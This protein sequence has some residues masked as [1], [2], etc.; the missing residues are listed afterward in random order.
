MR[1]FKKMLA[2]MVGAV[3]ILGNSV[4]GY[5]AG[6]PL[7][8]FKVVGYCSE[9]FNDPVE[10][11]QFD[12][13]TDVIYAFLIPGDDGTLIG[14]EKPEKLKALVAAA[15]SKGVRVSIAVG[16]WSYKN[17]PLQGNFEKMAGNVT[18]RKLFVKNTVQFLKAYQLDGLDLDWEFPTASAPYEALVRDLSV[19]LDAEGL[20]LSA[21]L[22][23]AWS[24]TGAPQ[25]SSLVTNTCLGYFDTINIMAYDADPT[26]PGHSPLW[27]ADTS[28][29]YWRLRGVPQEKII[30][31]VPFYGA[32]GWVQY[33]DIIKDN[34]DNAWRDRADI[35]VGTWGK[36]PVYY[37]GIATIQEKT[38]LALM[39][40][41][42][43]MIFDINEDT[44]DSS[45][46]LTA[47]HAVVEK[48]GGN[49]AGILDN[50]DLAVYGR[51][52]VFSE[53]SGEGVPYTD[54]QNRVMVPLRKCLEAIGASVA[55]DAQTQVITAARNGTTLTCTIGKREL[56]VNGTVIPMDT[57]AVIQESRTYVPVRFIY[58]AFGNTVT[59]HEN[60]RTVRVE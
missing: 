48:H 4:P 19:A 57:E 30:I 45:S 13:L 25:V 21:A 59:W 15:H 14:I 3:L 60:S 22:N 23:G 11:I 55:Y 38:R 34:P 31:G 46:L 42:G 12:K 54:Q 33:R 16:G 18:T 29:R 9:V 7:K 50:P 43:L 24:E 10:A 41:G 40:A 2:L 17:V 44:L 5:A 26:G 53:V 27:F 39:K 58:E 51:P 20:T 28:I 37:N 32:P 6:D 47:I 35:V 1:F 8:P 56:T 49:P 52:L 36:I